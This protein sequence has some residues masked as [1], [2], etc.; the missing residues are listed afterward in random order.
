MYIC[1]YVWMDVCF[2][3]VCF[4]IQTEHTDDAR[5]TREIQFRIAK[6]KA[7]FNKKKFLFTSNWTL[8]LREKSVKLLH[9]EHS[10]VRC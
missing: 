6:A 10:F 1:T 4:Y 5:C 9:L 2:L 7:S 3:F 8:D